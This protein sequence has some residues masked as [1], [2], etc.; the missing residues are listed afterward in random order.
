MLRILRV[1]LFVLVMA[2]ALSAD[3]NYNPA[4]TT[5]AGWSPCANYPGASCLTTAYF[6]AGSLFATDDI[7][8]SPLFQDAFN[9]WCEWNGTACGNGWTLDNGGGL[10]G[11]LNVTVATAQQF[12][13]GDVVLGGLTITIN[14]SGITTLPTVP[15][16]DSLVWSQGL[17][18]NYLNGNVVPPFYEMDIAGGACA[19]GTYST[20]NNNY[21]GGTWCGPAYPYQ[22]TSNQFYDQPKATYQPPGTTQKFFDA[23]AYLSVMDPTD[24]TLTVYDGVSYG[25]QNYVPEPSALV[26]LAGN[27]LVL[28][29]VL[30]RRRAAASSTRP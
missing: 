21:N 25:F 12:N 26:L 7:N 19:N 28:M 29:L 10:K 11:N 23:N 13:P 18:D 9:A 3:I 22:Y 17:Y 24:K 27:L 8:I 5:S 2:G 4:P 16:G 6:Q 20:S 14:T 1:S 15:V 30:R